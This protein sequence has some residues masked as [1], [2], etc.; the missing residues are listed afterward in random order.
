METLRVVQQKLPGFVLP[1]V[2]LCIWLVLLS[3][4]F[5]PLE[6]RFAVRL[7]AIFR[8]QAGA[9]HDDSRSFRRLLVPSRLLGHA[10]QRIS[11]GGLT[12]S[13]QGAFS[14]RSRTGRRGCVSSRPWSS[15]KSVSLGPPLEPPSAVAVAVPRYPSQ[16]GACR[17]VGEHASPPGRHDL[18]A[19]LRPRA[20]LCPGSGSAF[21]LGGSVSVIH[22]IVLFPWN[23]L[24]LLPPRQC[25]LALRQAGVVVRQPRRSIIGATPTTVPPMS[26]RNMRGCCRGLFA[27]SARSSCPATSDRRATAPIIQ[28]HRACSSS[29]WDRSC[30]DFLRRS[31]P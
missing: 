19:S 5:M 13:C 7:Q 30:R 21:S 23:H 14:S 11:P 31:I 15:V 28:R 29:C 26:T 17:L 20:S 24:G 12:P 3:I 4:V 6:R 10:T 16:S 1:A 25:A 18:H 27:C 9:D 2:R 8:N 22:V